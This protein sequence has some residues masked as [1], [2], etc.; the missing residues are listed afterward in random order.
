MIEIVQISLHKYLAHSVIHRNELE[1]MAH[2]TMLFPVWNQDG[3][4][5]YLMFSELFDN[6]LKE[7]GLQRYNAHDRVYDIGDQELVTIEFKAFGNVANYY[8]SAIGDV[9]DDLGYDCFKADAEE[10]Q[11]ALKPIV[12]NMNPERAWHEAYCQVLA[13]WE[14]TPEQWDTGEGTEYDYNV[15]FVG[16]L[17]QYV[18]EGVAKRITELSEEYAP[19]KVTKIS[20]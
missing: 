1:V 8:Q 15:A 7:R 14:Y 4:D 20:S 18:L 19:K 12:D 9:I 10:L 3:V 2:D 11:K 13:L 6:D 17:P 5:S 16:L